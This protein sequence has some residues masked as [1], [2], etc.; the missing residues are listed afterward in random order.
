[1]QRPAL[2]IFSSGLAKVLQSLFALHSISNNQSNE[3]SEEEIM[4]YNHDVRQVAFFSILKS[5]LAQYSN[6]QF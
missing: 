2:Q 1:M 5:N 4:N 3:N 6:Q